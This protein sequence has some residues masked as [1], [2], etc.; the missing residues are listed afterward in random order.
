MSVTACLGRPR[1]K[2]KARAKGLTLVP[3]RQGRA[4]VVT[5]QMMRSGR[6][7]SELGA[8]T[9]LLLLLVV[10]V[11]VVEEA[12]F[13][14]DA[15]LSLS[16]VVVVVL[17]LLLVLLLLRASISSS[18]LGVVLA[19]MLS[20][21]FQPMLLWRVGIDPSITRGSG[22]LSVMAV[23]MVAEGAARKLAPV[24]V[25]TVLDTRIGVNPTQPRIEPWVSCLVFVDFFHSVDR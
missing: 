12:S 6:D 9:L 17:L 5:T 1:V 24:L 3:V 16:V 8:M 11:L 19:H 22:T 7:K 15:L 18:M 14:A 23:M 21:G 4:A 20:I 25:L 13:H 10:D 2:Y